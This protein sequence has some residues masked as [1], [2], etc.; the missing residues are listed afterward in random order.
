MQLFLTTGDVD[1]FALDTAA[2][3]D[4]PPLL[5]STDA[6]QAIEVFR[7]NTPGAAEPIN[8]EILMDGSIVPGSGTANMLFFVEAS[9]FE[10]YDPSFT[11]IVLFSQFGTEPGGSASASGF[12]EWGLRAFD[13]EPIPEPSSMALLSL[14]GLGGFLRRRSRKKANDSAAV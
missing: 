11:N 9:K 14:V 4:T 6:L 5:S 1:T 10:G 3:V 13:T 12:E 7:M 2:A 8:Y